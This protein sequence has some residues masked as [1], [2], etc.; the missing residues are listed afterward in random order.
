MK[1]PTRVAAVLGGTLLAISLA[2]CA[3]T[4]ASPEATTSA[5]S[6]AVAAP[7][8]PGVAAEHNDADVTFA[9]M[10][11]VHHQGALE[12]SELAAQQ[13]TSPDVKDVAA[14]IEAAQLPEI[15]LMESWLTAWGEPLQASDHA[16]MDHGGM[17]M[18]GM[19]QEQVMT[20]LRKGTGADF[21]NQFLTAMIAHHEGA[22]V[23][24][25]EQLRDGSNPEALDLAQRII[26]AQKTEIQQMQQLLQDL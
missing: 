5:P 15:Q 11:T 1:S 19:S 2:G 8:D 17:D 3:A 21:D 7:S 23:M 6:T 22:V 16:G 12:M 4:T 20:E 26:D 18:N 9:Q 24:A 10:M 14:T 13:A 25:E